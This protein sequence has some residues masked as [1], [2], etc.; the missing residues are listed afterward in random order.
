MNKRLIIPV[1][2][3]FCS[4]SAYNESL[5]VSIPLELAQKDASA[6]EIRSAQARFALGIIPLDGIER[7]ENNVFD[8]LVFGIMAQSTTLDTGYALQGYERFMHRKPGVLTYEIKAY[9]TPEI[10]SNLQVKPI[11]PA[12]KKLPINEAPK[13]LPKKLSSS[14]VPISRKP[15]PQKDSTTARVPLGLQTLMLAK[16]RG[17]TAETDLKQV[18]VIACFRPERFTQQIFKS[19]QGRTEETLGHYSTGEWVRIY[20]KQEYSPEL[21]SRTRSV[22]PEAWAC[23]YGR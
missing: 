4:C 13:P 16:G 7:F 1:F 20:I 17:T 6:V 19:Y 8:E 2:V 18:V 21:R 15:V 10:K 5:M 22:F 11:K 9:Y 3:L 14:P 23:E 12:V